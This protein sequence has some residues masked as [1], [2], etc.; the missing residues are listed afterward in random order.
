MAAMSVRNLAGKTE[1]ESCPAV[2]R[3][4]AMERFEDALPLREGN[5]WTVVG[6]FDGPV[7]LDGEADLTI[8]TAMLDRKSVV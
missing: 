3:L 8:P 2:A 7:R 4:Y 6:H 5:A 1:A